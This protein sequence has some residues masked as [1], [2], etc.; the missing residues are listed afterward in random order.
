MADSVVAIYD[1]DEWELAFNDDY[2][3]ASASRIHWR[4]EDSGTL[5][6]EVAAYDDGVG[7]YTLTVSELEIDDAH[8]NNVAGATPIT[9]GEP[10]EASVDYPAD[11]DFF[12][13]EAEA[14]TIYQVDVTL[15][16]LADSKAAVF[17]AEGWE[18][19]F[20][21]DFGDTPG[22][23]IFWRPEADA[24]LYVGVAGFG[25]D[26]GSYTLT[27]SESDEADDHA[28]SPEDA[29]AIA[30]GTP[31]QGTINYGGDTDVF[32]FEAQA[33][34]VYQVDVTL[35][36]LG[37][38]TVALSDA[39][40]MELAFN[41]DFDG[42]ASRLVW[43]ATGSG[44]VYVAVKAYEADAGTYTLSVAELDIDDDDGNSLEDAT[45]VT[46]GAPY[47]GIVDYP[48]DVDLFSFRAEAGQTYQIDVE[49]GTLDD[50]LVQVLGDDGSEL[51]FNDDFGET[52]ASRVVWRAAASATFYVEVA[53]YGDSVG[54]YTLTVGATTAT[55]APAAGPNANSGGVGHEQPQPQSSKRSKP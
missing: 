15:G 55:P 41:D 6:V 35:G 5:Y 11:S 30:V 8:A 37:D 51:A 49:L 16:T 52:G 38:S 50:S 39:G 25:A 3:D 36:T 29:T 46:V 40:G 32:S 42:S 31:T 23:R 53:G 47:E 7:S 24:T 14:G 54:S 21:D 10:V 26:V 19:A 48:G 33:G 45:P 28:D 22:S 27:V 20:N 34:R 4:A 2:D 13:F 43:G 1:L 17:D 44:T 9:V 18:L 12:S